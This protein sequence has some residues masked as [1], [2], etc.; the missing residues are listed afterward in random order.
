MTHGHIDVGP[1]A[2]N[3]PSHNPTDVLVRCV[4]GIA[5]IGDESVTTETGFP[6]HVGDDVTIHIDPA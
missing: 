5:Y 4:D 1:K 6:L 3:L 2:T